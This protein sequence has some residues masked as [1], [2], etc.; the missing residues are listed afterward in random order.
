MF[1]LQ[2]CITNGAFREEPSYLLIRR[3][4]KITS[5]LGEASQS[6]SESGERTSKI[7]DSRRRHIRTRGKSSKSFRQGKK[8]KETN[9]RYLLISEMHDDVRLQ[10]LQFGNA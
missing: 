7:N 6:V 10:V 1:S 5:K 3:R 9:E 2:S 8:K 4:N